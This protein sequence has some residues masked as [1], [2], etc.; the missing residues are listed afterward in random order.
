MQSGVGEITTLPG[1]TDYNGGVFS[2][3]GALA[4]T[5]DGGLDAYANTLL[6][7]MPTTTYQGF[8]TVFMTRDLGDF[9]D[10]SFG[11]MPFRLDW[12][13]G[14]R[15]KEAGVTYNPRSG[16]WYIWEQP[17]GA[18]VLLGKYGV[19]R[20]GWHYVKIVFNPVTSYYVSLR[21]DNNFI[22][23]SDRKCYD[24]SSDGY[25]STQVAVYC[26]AD[27]GDEVTVWFDNLTATYGES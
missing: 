26:K 14:T 4:M 6:P 10:S 12:Y 15:Y 17:S 19:Q 7:S 1:D 16:N 9:S 2:G 25:S 18:P 20:W 27:T 8:S 24:V 5:T 13:T 23:I 22:D 3:S 11:I 21:I